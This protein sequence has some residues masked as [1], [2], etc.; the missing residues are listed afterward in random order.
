MAELRINPDKVCAFV[1]AA[2]EVSGLVRVLPDK[3][4]PSGDDSALTDMFEPAGGMDPR[5][6]EMIRFVA[7]LNVEEQT[8]LLALIMLGRGDF[9]IEEWDDALIEA[10]DAI[11]GRSAD[12]MIGD[13]ALPA[14]LLEALDAFDKSCD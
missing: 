5:R 6:V 12:F 10:R 4:M 3:L 13:S 8:D 11:D 14:Y 7:G 1:E 2:R 9:G